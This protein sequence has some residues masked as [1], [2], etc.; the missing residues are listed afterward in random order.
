[1]L[2]D[3][4]DMLAE[5]TPGSEVEARVLY[6]TP[7]LNTVILT[8]RDIRARDVFGELKNLTGMCMLMYRWEQTSMRKA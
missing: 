1:M 7:T 5:Y 3:E 6:I 8:L 2:R 4:L